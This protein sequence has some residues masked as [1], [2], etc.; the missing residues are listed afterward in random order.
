MTRRF[1]R[2]RMP[3]LALGALLSSVP[4]LSANETLPTVE[5]RGSREEVR[6]EVQTFVGSITRMDGE[7]VGRWRSFVC[8]MIVG[9]S[10]PQGEFI[11]QHII[12]VYDSVRKKKRKSDEPCAPNLF[13][14]I[15]D[16]ADQVIADWKERDPGM[17][18][19]KERDGVTRSKGPG[20]VQTWHN[21]TE[22]ASGMDPLI[23]NPNAPP[24]VLTSGSP[25]IVSP[26]SEALTA[27]VVLV[28]SR[29]TGKV[30]L[31][32]LTDYIAMVSLAQLDLTV[33]LSGIDSILRLFA[34]PRPDVPPEG[35]TE[36]DYAFLRALYR[37][38]YEPKHQRRDIRARM[39][40]EL[41]PR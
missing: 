17:F 19:W 32:Q 27:V 30:T 20:A 39:V 34:Q 40:R 4:A 8:P 25:R 9:V 28:D 5:V 7:L 18:R 38:S 21:A 24:A 41:A 29:A 11:R 23:E 2:G 16:E 12:D 14:I 22:V 36:W 31:A 13:V 33:N 3:M 10:E 26:V 35:L 37:I 1:Q 15:S 6:R